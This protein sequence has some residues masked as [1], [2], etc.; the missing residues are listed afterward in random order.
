MALRAQWTNFA[1]NWYFGHQA[2]IRFTSGMPMVLTD[3]IINQVEGVAAISD[4]LGNLLFYTD[5][6]NVWDRNHQLMPNGTGLLG[7]F[8]STQ[9]G[10]I[11]PNIAVPGRYYLF[12]PQAY[13]TPSANCYYSEI[14][15]SLNAGMGDVIAATKNTLLFSNSSEKITAVRHAN[16]SD[17]WVVGHDITPGAGNQ[18]LAYRI[19]ALSGLIST[20]VVSS[21]GEVLTG[22]GTAGPMRTSPDGRWLVMASRGTGNVQLFHFNNATGAVSQ[23]V[24]T[25]NP[26]WHLPYGMEFS[27]SGNLLYITGGNY[28]NE[29]SSSTPC[30]LGYTNYDGTYYL[31]QLDISLCTETEILGSGTFI[32]ADYIPPYTATDWGGQ[33]QLGPDG[34]IYIARASS[35][36]LA[37]V[38]HP[39]LYG[40]NCGY[41]HN[42]F[43]LDTGNTGCH[44]SQLGLPNFLTIGHVDSI[45]YSIDTSQCSLVNFYGYLFPGYDSLVW[46]F[47]DPP[48][49]AANNSHLDNPSHNYQQSGIYHPF[50]VVYRGCY[51]DT[52]F[53]SLEMST[54]IPL[55]EFTFDTVYLRCHGVGVQFMLTDTGNVTY[56]W[57]LGNDS[58]S[59]QLSP[60]TFYAFGQTYTVQV[61][62]VSPAGCTSTYSQSLYFAED[63]LTG[64]HEINVFTPDGNGINDLLDF[65]LGNYWGECARITVYNRWGTEVFTS[66][67]TNLQW[68]GRLPAGEMA[69]E[70]IY[71]WVAEV[72]GHRYHGMVHVFY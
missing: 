48:S 25:I 61:T 64:F 27:P 67:I 66:G 47:D 56:S 38:E 68:D 5:G 9:S 63:S 41:L 45:G 51:P 57:N 42:G 34:R 10:V 20:P 32:H 52:L 58:V 31:Y 54:T 8:S 39:D 71:Y 17:I 60:Q 6:Q 21:G 4:N 33:C 35:R 46:Y 40:V 1:N 16:G 55:P 50:L 24:A 43:D 14:D 26:G 13:E 37:V 12:T 49:G 62:A 29:Q 3:G 11:V 44:F 2:G 19:S 53:T 65:G 70:G 18:F 36:Y 23:P 28:L 59:D 72:K 15:M 22:W 30:G 7:H 69:T